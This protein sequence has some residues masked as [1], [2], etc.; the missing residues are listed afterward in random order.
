MIKFK[1]LL[2]KEDFERVLQNG[3]MKA[4][5]KEE[6]EKFM[7]IKNLSDSEIQ[8]VFDF[9][10]VNR[11]KF[12]HKQKISSSKKDDKNIKISSKQGLSNPISLYCKHAT[13]YNLL[14]PE[15]ELVLGRKIK[16][17]RNAKQTLEIIESPIFISK[18]DSDSRF[19]IESSFHKSVEDLILDYKKE[20]KKSVDEG[21]DAKELFVNSNLRLV[22]SIAKHHLNEGLDF[23]DVIQEG[24]IGLIRA[25]DKFDPDRGFRF[26]TMASWW[27][28]QAIQR[29]TANKGRTIRVPVYVS[30]KLKKLNSFESQY[31]QKNDSLPEM[32][33]YM[34]HLNL[35]EAEVK[36]LLDCR[37]NVSSLDKYSSDDKR[38]SI[39][40]FVESNA[41]GPMDE[42][43]NKSLK[44]TIQNIIDEMNLQDI[45]K[46]IVYS[47]L[48]ICGHEKKKREQIRN[49]YNVSYGQ[50]KK[51]NDKVMMH[52]RSSS[53]RYQLQGYYEDIN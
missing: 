2:T 14:T 34:N 8:E 13:Q 6:V 1:P 10:E 44:E 27:I 45:E 31:V 3:D 15:E 9:C 50:I 23:E 4:K 40:D 36:K 7:K 37:P 19:Y 30:E 18:I 11:I 46:G 32:E 47:S 41:P 21:L 22:M 48:G 16:K 35:S 20:L 28:E 26:A 42:F 39:G 25:V 24:N 5:T 51:L 49:E 52:L 29:G 33:D 43:N 17:G 12:S 53:S 38:T